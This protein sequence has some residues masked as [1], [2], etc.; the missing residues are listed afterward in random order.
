MIDF[1]GEKVIL[2]GFNKSIAM[3]RM[4]SGHVTVSIVEFDE[5]GWELPIEA[6]RL[7]LR[8]EEFR[9]ERS[10]SSQNERS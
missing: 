3:S 5:S 10:S 1:G 6:V 2:G 9:Q 7:G 8:D 4:P